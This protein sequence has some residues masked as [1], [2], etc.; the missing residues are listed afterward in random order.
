MYVFYVHE[1]EAMLKGGLRS[2]A[3]FLLGGDGELTHP[4]KQ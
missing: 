2:A 4:C 1:A 3:W